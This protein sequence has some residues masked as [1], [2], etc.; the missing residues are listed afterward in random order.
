M[1][2]IFEEIVSRSGAGGEITISRGYGEVEVT[3]I[4]VEDVLTG[5]TT[6]E[7]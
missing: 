4:L 2:D 3:Y 7:E 6:E 5:T 1:T